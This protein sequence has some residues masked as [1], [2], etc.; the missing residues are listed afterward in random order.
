MH[1]KQ[2]VFILVMGASQMAFCQ[3]QRIAYSYSGGAASKFDGRE[4][5][6]FGQIPME[7]IFQDSIL[8]DSILKEVDKQKKQTV[9]A[10]KPLPKKPKSKSP[11]KKTTNLALAPAKEGDEK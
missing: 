4:S 5:G 11:Q 1:I 7:K 2:L 6:N 10:T 9:P 3:T 8:I